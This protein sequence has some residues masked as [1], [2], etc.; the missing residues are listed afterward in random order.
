M[1]WTWMLPPPFDYGGGSFYY[2]IE[3]DQNT[4]QSTQFPS[5]TLR[6][7]CSP[8]GAGNLACE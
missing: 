3:T 7:P 4:Q 5:I 1:G 8:L 6:P 2:N